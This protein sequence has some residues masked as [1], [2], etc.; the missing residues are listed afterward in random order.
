V[1]AREPDCNRRNL[2]ELV[3]FIEAGKIQPYVSATYPWSGRQAIHSQPTG[4]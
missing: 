1:A 3:E 4:G 2:Q